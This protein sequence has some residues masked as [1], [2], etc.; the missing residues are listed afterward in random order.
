MANDPPTIKLPWW[1]IWMWS[2]LSLQRKGPLNVHL[3]YLQRLKS[4]S[5]N[6]SGLVEVVQK[7]T[8]TGRPRNRDLKKHWLCLKTLCKHTDVFSPAA[9]GFGARSYS[10][11]ASMDDSTMVQTVSS[12]LW[13]CYATDSESDRFDLLMIILQL[14]K[15]EINRVPSV[16]NFIL[17]F[18]YILYN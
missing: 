14:S 2:R 18:K 9:R 4:C 13:L 8:L 10:S 11:H 7:Y 6:T 5:Y 15:K 12:S 16:V 17:V 1:H 3:T